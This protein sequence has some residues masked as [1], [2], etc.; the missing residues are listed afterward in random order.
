ML[1]FN[2]WY[3]DSPRRDFLFF[4]PFQQLFLLPPFL[5]F[6]TKNLLDNSIKFKKK[7]WLHFVPGL[8][9]LLFSFIVWITDYVILDEYYFYADGRDM[10]FDSWYQITG[11]ISL[12]VYILLSLQQYANYRQNSY[13]TVSYADSI[14]VTWLPRFLLALSGLL[15]IRIFFFILNPEWANFGQKYWYYVAFCI[16]FYYISISGYIH[17]IKLTLPYNADLFNAPQ[18]ELLQEKTSSEK[19]I[20]S[21][22]P[23]KKQEV[24]QEL[25]KKI[26]FLMKEEKIFTKPDLTLFDLANHLGV[27]SKVVSNTINEGFNLNF[28]DFI[29][30]HRVKEVMAKV[31][32][33]ETQIKTLL[34][35]AYD[36]G[37]NSK[38]TF[39]RAFK[40][41][42][43]L[44]PMEYLKKY[45]EK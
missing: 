29:N 30:S 26:L 45:A 10:D 43:H 20:D 21:S 37:F 11:F 24:D 8:V 14:L 28:N 2:G 35:I 17:A 38:S 5:Y 33:N 12:V 6:Y 34:G 19:R 16:L 23:S 4:I 36:C 1:G 27:H 13:Q 41:H 3:S 18:K 39:N 22:V 42:S 7:D 15:V 9:Y 44:T 25:K 31:Q 32:T 40:K